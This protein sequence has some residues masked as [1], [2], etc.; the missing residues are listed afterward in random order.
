M[1]RFLMCKRQG[2]TFLK[3]TFERTFFKEKYFWFVCRSTYMK[4]H[5]PNSP[6]I[7]LNRK[8]SHIIQKQ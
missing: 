1:F 2:K 7:F 4:I 5:V 8:I 6:N 3:T